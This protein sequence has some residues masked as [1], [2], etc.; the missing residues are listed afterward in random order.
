MTLKKAQ[1]SPWVQPNDCL[2]RARPW[3]PSPALPPKGH[4]GPDCIDGA[5]AAVRP[6]KEPVHGWLSRAVWILPPGVL[7]TRNRP[8]PYSLKHNN[9]A[10]RAGSHLIPRSKSCLRSLCLNCQP[11]TDAALSLPLQGLIKVRGDKCW[12]DLTCM[13]FHYEVSTDMAVTEASV[14][15]LS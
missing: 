11:T 3:V 10:F 9:L 7:P 2:K 13:D 8:L 14:S 12:L 1:N 6:Q 5:L 15:L 4:R